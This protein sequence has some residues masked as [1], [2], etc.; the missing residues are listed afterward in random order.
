MAA[1]TLLRLGR[2]GQDRDRHWDGNQR[3]QKE[4]LQRRKEK[5]EEEW[6]WSN[7]SGKQLGKWDMGGKSRFCLFVRL[8]WHRS[9]IAIR[10]EL[11]G[12]TKKKLMANWHCQFV[13]TFFFVFPTQG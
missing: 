4:R 3:G 12:K 8:V 7:G 5:V 6:Q 9:A 2:R 1:N 13:T 10:L 11:N